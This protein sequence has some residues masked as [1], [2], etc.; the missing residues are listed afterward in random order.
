MQHWRKYQC[1]TGVAAT[2]DV[3]TLIGGRRNLDWVHVARDMDRWWVLANTVL[4]MQFPET[5]GNFLT[6]FLVRRVNFIMLL[7][8]CIGPQ[9]GTEQ[10]HV[11]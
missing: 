3:P 11:Y 4:T 10:L 5:G 2:E 7:F 9:W 6:I 1:F 8:L